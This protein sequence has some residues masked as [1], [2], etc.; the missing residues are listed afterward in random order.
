MFSRFSHGVELSKNHFN[1]EMSELDMGYVIGQIHQTVNQ[2][3]ILADQDV[4]I[5][6][7]IE[8]NIAINRLAI[9]A[10]L[11]GID[12]EGEQT[13]GGSQK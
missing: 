2:L 11:I 6:A 3:I 8:L 7:R 13:N 12:V 10:G 9:A 5:K 1:R 4:I